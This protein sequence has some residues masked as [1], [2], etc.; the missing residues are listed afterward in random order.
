MGE[1]YNDE[2]VYG[3]KIVLACFVLY[4]YNLWYIQTDKSVLYN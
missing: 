3:N 2:M 1:S 4:N